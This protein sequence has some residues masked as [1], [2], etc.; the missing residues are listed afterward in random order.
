MVLLHPR[1]VAVAC[2]IAC[3]NAVAR[4]G[5]TTKPPPPPVAGVVVNEDGSPAAGAKVELRVPRGS[6][7]HGGR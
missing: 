5:E 3:S 6:T 1:V 7:H 4:A 2:F